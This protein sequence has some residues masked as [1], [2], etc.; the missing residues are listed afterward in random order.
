MEQYIEH[1]ELAKKKYLVADHILTMT[2]PLV[3]DS[4]LLL[5]SLDNIFLVYTNCMAAL[6]AK[7]N[8]LSAI[9]N[10]FEY[11]FTIYKRIFED[12]FKL[13]KEY[14][15]TMREIKTIILE[16]K[17][18]PVEFSRNNNLVIC[19]EDY[20]MRELTYPLIKEYLHKAK[21]FI[22]EITSIIQND[23]QLR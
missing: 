5:V 23:G 4:K 6:L 9:S 13:N 1:L 2:Y 7:E 3:K 8:K 19:M 18:S 21:L 17:K 14:S 12:K 10:T 20:R 16:H 22:G 15:M 11:K